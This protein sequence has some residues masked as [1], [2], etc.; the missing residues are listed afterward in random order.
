MKLKNIFRTLALSLF[1][2]CISTGCEKG[3]VDID[4]NGPEINDP[5][6]VDQEIDKVVGKICLNWNESYS[7]VNSKMNGFEKTVEDT[8]YIS[9]KA[10]KG[11]YQISYDFV[12]G[13]LR[14][15]VAVIPTSVQLDN[16]QVYSLDGYTYIGEIDGAAVYANSSE[17]N[18]AMIMKRV[19]DNAE[20]LTIGFAPIESELFESV[21]PIGVGNVKISDVGYDSMTIIWSIIGNPTDGI[22]RG[23]IS[24]STS[25]DLSDAKTTTTSCHN[26]GT[27]SMKLTT[28]AANQTYYFT[29]FVEIDGVRYESE[30][31]SQE[32][33]YIK[34]YAIGD[35]WPDAVNPQGVV[36]VINGSGEHGKILSLD[37]DYI[38]WD[39]QGLFCTDYRC[40]NTSDGSKNDMGKVEPFAKWVYNHGSGWYGPA[41]YELFF[42]KSDLEKINSTLKS[43]G[44]PVMNGF[45][46]SSTQ[47]NGN[48]SYVVTATE[49]F[50][51]GYENKYTFY[52][53][54]SEK[55]SVRAMKKY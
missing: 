52:N 41:Q 49:S 40:Y 27:F 45:Y 29:A 24:Y 37:Q 26:S 55:K 38:Q 8:E 9:Y 11:D 19:V 13:H 39:R 51:M 34:T 54:K 16:S 43:G 35:F 15:S 30:V 14:S 33:E 44:Y 31:L 5:D 25:P 10:K 28:L 22:D 46:W 1:F 47:Y 23:G 48:N 4:V 21:Q 42:S 36:C 32:L 17:G 3:S 7:E 12:D 2:A 6:A 18:L 50:Y 20:Y 53:T